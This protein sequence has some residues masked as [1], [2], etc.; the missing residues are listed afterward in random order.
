MAVENLRVQQL[1]EDYR[2]YPIDDHG[3]IRIMHFDLPATT[4]VGDATSTIEL[5]LLP[6]GRVRI[7]LDLCKIK[8]SAFGAARTLTVGH[9]AYQTRPT[10]N[11]PEAEAL[12]AFTAPALDVSAAGVKV[13]DTDPLKYDVYS[14]AGV[15]AVAQVLGGTIP[16]GATLSGYITYVYE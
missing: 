4:V 15:M 2:K 9:R 16:V 12:A 5:G 13:M 11:A 1:G 8:H 6:P 10:G 14:V 3:K 7:L